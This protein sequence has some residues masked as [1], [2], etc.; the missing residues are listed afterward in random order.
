MTRPMKKKWP[1]L[2]AKTTIATLAYHP[3]VDDLDRG[4][5]LVYLRLL[6]A[7]ATQRSKTIGIHNSAL[8]KNPKTAGVSLRSLEEKGYVRV[9]FNGTGQRTIEV[10]A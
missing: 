10:R 5:L 1:K 6:S 9:V 7:V 3:I 4:A 2:D 8:H